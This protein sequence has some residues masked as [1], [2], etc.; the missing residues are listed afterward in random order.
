MDFYEPLGKLLET[1]WFETK[2]SINYDPVRIGWQLT[3]M[4]EK[5]T[6]RDIL[7]VVNESVHEK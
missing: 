2:F 5:T 6:E 1:R 4:V 3:V 7:L